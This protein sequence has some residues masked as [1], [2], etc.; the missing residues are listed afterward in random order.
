VLCERGIRAFPGH[1]RFTLDLSIVPAVRRHS[2]LPILVDPSHATGEAA[3][4]PSM[5][6]AAAAAGADGVLL[7]IHPDPANARCDG[8][9]ALSGEALAE[10]A[11]SLQAIRA[12]LHGAE[13]AP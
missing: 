6:R 13:A 4:V 10:L 11:P 8:R 3:Y 2:R 7:E 9:Q 1:A 5:A 12:A